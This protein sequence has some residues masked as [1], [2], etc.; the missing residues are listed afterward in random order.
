[1]L[2]LNYPSY[3]DLSEIINELNI[4]FKK[5]TALIPLKAGSL[6]PDF[7][8]QKEHGKWQK[9]FNGREVRNTFFLREILNKPLVISFYSKEWK[10]HGLDLLKN[11]DLLQREIIASGGNLMVINSEKE[12]TDKLAWDNSLS[13]NF[14]FDGKHTIAEKFRIFSENDPIWNRFSGIDTNVP[15]LATYVISPTGQI[16]YDHIEQDFTEPFASKDILT[17]VQQSC[18]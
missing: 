15:L 8:L 12:S 10:G 18:A 7:T 17:A 16:V 4:P 14:Y 1:M 13:L 9:F 5:R 11:L 6:S 3:F 2:A